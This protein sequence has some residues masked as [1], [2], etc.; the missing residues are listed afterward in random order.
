MDDD[1]LSQMSL[2]FPTAEDANA[3]L[4]RMNQAMPSIYDLFKPD[5]IEELTQAFQKLQSF[6]FHEGV[7]RTYA[8]V[9]TAF[10]EKG[11]KSD[12]IAEA[13]VAAIQ[14]NMSPETLRRT[15]FG[16]HVNQVADRVRPQLS[17]SLRQGKR[18]A[19]VRLMQEIRKLK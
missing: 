11:I 16:L 8:D 14:I 17:T 13:I 18:S 15:A 9:I 10:Q 6:R 12:R 2:P 3:I 5:Q 1:R 4:D 7:L 19:R